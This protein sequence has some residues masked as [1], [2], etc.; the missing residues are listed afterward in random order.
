M[1]TV[2]L[3]RTLLLPIIVFLGVISL[4]LWWRSRF[5]APMYIHLLA[6]LSTLIASLL[7]WMAWVVDDPLKGRVVWMVVI[8]PAF[9]Y[10]TFG[11]YGGKIIRKHLLTKTRADDD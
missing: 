11:F 1:T 9:V 6:A 7:V 2:D 3:L 10:L 5:W 4:A 8:F